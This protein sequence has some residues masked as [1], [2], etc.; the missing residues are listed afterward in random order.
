MGLFAFL[1]CLAITEHPWV[2]DA[3]EPWKRH[4]LDSVLKCP[5]VSGVA[6]ALKPYGLGYG[7]QACYFTT[8]GLSFPICSVG[9]RTDEEKAGERVRV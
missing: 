4:G 1:Y 2:P 6:G 8:W 7:V 9:H 5:K 3:G